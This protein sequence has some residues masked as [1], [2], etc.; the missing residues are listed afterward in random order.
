LNIVFGGTAVSSALGA[1]AFTYNAITADESVIET[2]MGAT[3]GA[4]VGVGCGFA[5][6]AFY[7]VT[8]PALIASGTSK[9]TR[10]YFDTGAKSPDVDNVAEPSPYRI[11]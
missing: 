5:F 2:V 4:V 3:K 11:Y 10:Y 8:V 1:S 9:L 7:P 6:C